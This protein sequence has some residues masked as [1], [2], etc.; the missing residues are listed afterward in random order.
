MTLQQISYL[1]EDTE[2]QGSESTQFHKIGHF[3]GK[4]L[5]HYNFSH[6]KNIDIGLELTFLL[7]THIGVPCFTWPA[8]TVTP[9]TIGSREL[10]MY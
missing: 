9:I 8:S 10:K 3:A 7:G 2:N 6:V 5:F 1:G 4:F